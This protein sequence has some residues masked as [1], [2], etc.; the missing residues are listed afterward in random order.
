MKNNIIVIGSGCHHN[1]LGVIRALG[2]AGYGVELITIGNLKK[3]YISASKYV[4][5]HHALAEIKELAAY[6]LFREQKPDNR[7]EIIISCADAVTE[8]LN[9]F[10]DRL[11]ERYIFPGVPI[12]GKIVELMDKTTMSS[13]VAK[14]G[15]MAP[16][17]WNLPKDKEKVVFPCITK[18]YVSSHGS[19][20]DVVVCRSHE[21]LDDI[22][23]SNND[24]LFAQAYIDKRE[25]VQLIGCSLNGGQDII[26]PGMSKVL[27]S[28]PN[29]NTGFLEYGPIDPFYSDVVEKAKLY[30][31]DCKY[32]GLFSFEIMRD[33]HDKVWFL[34]INFRNDGNAWCVTRSGVNLPVIW[35]KACLGEG[36]SS[37][38]KT[39]KM[40][41]M[42]PEFQDIK[43]VLQRKVSL[44]QWIKDWRRT[45]F[46]ME[47]DKKDPKP[48]WQ[49]IINKLI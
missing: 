6:L 35:V 31:Q 20:S 26:I 33:K 30:I 29:T 40:I 28:Q 5:K 22:L 23:A 8:H 24:E 14:R 9:K 11:S 39:P 38:I 36:Y 17:V 3:H 2:E 44:L 48:F 25:E 1:T 47:Y 15:V 19:K 34:E 12:Q 49:Y 42:M 7:K 10:Y 45:D 4:R 27:R 41:V 21:Q 46:F 32:S 18:A 16:V 43:L 13:M 37:E